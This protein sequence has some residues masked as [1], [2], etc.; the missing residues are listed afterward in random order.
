MEKERVEEERETDI[1]TE[2]E[3]QRLRERISRMVYILLIFRIS[4]NIQ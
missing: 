3:R 2:R 4:V 1:E